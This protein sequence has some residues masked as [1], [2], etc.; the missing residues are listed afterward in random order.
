MSDLYRE[1]IL[2]LYRHPLNY[3][4]LDDATHQHKGVNPGCG[5][6]IILYLI[7]QND[8][9]IDCSFEGKG[10][11]LCF[12]GASLVTEKMQGM[13]IQEVSQI[14]LEQVYQWLGIP[15]EPSRVKCVGLA[16]R[17]VQNMI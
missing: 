6:D 4:S 12:A 9:V 11:A 15:M 2:D 1:Y 7:V 3:H 13:T 17:T 10:C 16:L 8:K 14:S 5:D